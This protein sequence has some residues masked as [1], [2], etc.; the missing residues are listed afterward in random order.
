M[1]FARR[2]GRLSPTPTAELTSAVLGQAERRPHGLRDSR[3]SATRRFT[4]HSSRRRDPHDPAHR[5]FA[6]LR[7]PVATRRQ[8][9]RRRHGRRGHSRISRCL[10]PLPAQ[11]HAPPE[12]PHPSSC[13]PPRTRRRNRRRRI[14]Q[15]SATS[16]PHS[17]SRL[18]RA[19]ELRCTS[20][21]DPML[22]K[23]GARRQNNHMGRLRA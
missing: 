21:T 23:S 9:G 20:K 8:P 4:A 16:P 13:S 10:R 5:R 6:R 11:A 17:T 3:G 19:P 18:T 12:R 15:E 7:E 14:E 1:L 22:L 2:C